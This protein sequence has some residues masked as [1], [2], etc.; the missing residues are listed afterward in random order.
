MIT[1]VC[2]TLDFN[3]TTLQ[4]FYPIVIQCTLTFNE[5]LINLYYSSE[6]LV[7]LIERLKFNWRRSKLPISPDAQAQIL[8]PQSSG[9]VLRLVLT[10]AGMLGYMSRVCTD[11]VQTRDLALPSAHVNTL[12]YVERVVKRDYV[13]AERTRLH[14]RVDQIATPLERVIYMYRVVK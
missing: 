12:K 13:S 5:L 11:S 10:S 3:S 9:S 14:R 8:K 7:S 4:Q 2:R 6:E 1:L